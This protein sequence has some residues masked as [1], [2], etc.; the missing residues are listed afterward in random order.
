MTG[1]SAMDGGTLAF[2]FAGNPNEPSVDAR[3]AGLRVPVRHRHPTA[4]ERRRDK[5]KLVFFTPAEARQPPRPKAVKGLL[6]EM[7]QARDRHPSRPQ[8]QG[9]RCGQGDDRGRRV[10]RRPHRLHAGHDRQRLVRQH[11]P[12]ALVRRPAA[13]GRPVPGASAASASMWRATPAAFPVRTGCRS[14]R[15]WPTC[16]PTPPPPIS[17]RSCGGKC[18]PRPS[19]W[20]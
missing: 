15:T 17:W 13:G 12:A 7:K 1:C 20:S 11:R 9:L 6:E 8:A 2:G 10:R 14:R 19:R 4:P 16:R 3:R 18:R 5:F